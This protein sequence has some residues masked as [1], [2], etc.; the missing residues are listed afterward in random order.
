MAHATLTRLAVHVGARRLDVAL[1]PTA[2]LG[3]VLDA[4]APQ[5]SHAL[6][7]DSA[8][9]LLDRSATVGSQLEDGGA[10]HAA[11][12]APAPRGRRD[13]GAH[14]AVRRRP[15]VEAALLSVG[16]VAALTVAAVVLLPAG[17]APSG[18]SAV[19]GALGCALGAFGC[20]LGRSVARTAATVCGPLLGLA[21]AVLV[22]APVDDP[23]RRLAVVAGLAAAA[24]VAG[25]RHVAV[26]ADRR[27]GEA[28]GDDVSG[29]VLVATSVASALALVCLLLGLPTVV[30]A[31]VLVGATP[32]ALRALPQNALSVP[33]DQLVDLARVSRTAT[34]VR[35]PGPRGLGRVSATQVVRTVAFAERRKAAGTVVASALPALLLPVVLVSTQPGT[36]A[37]WGAVALTVCVV[38]AL[39]LGPRTAR[40]AVARWWPRAGAGVV[41]L[42]AVSF[43]PADSRAV[44]AAG[45]AVV[46]LAV[47]ALAIPLARG[48]SSVVASRAADGLEGLGI[49]L[50]LPAALVAAGAVELLRQVTS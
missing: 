24:V 4:V 43:A 28:T 48:W 44:V 41:V 32:L 12:P 30:L 22:V 1:D 23:G 50:A 49:V 20:A 3:D 10:V 47:A 31:A 39:A 16:A 29:V 18:A 2:A 19:L 14:A 8:G 11:L 25:V 34:S 5:T 9:R 46:A 13:A 35:G 40:G 38:L 42:E 27:A 33:D 37:G 36:V 15:P 45:V 26:Q 7:V 6:L 17:V 21:T